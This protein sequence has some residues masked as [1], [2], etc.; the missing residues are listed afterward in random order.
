M[1]SPILDLSLLDGSNGFVIRESASV[2]SAGDINGDGLDD[3]IVGNPFATVDGNS[4]AGES[5]VVFGDAAVG[6]GGV[7]DLTSINGSN[8]FVIS[9]FNA[10]DFLGASV[11]GAGDINDDGIDD[12][13]VG[14][15]GVDPNGN[16]FAGA[17][18]VVFG[19]ASVGAGGAVDLATLNGSNGFA[20]NGIDAGDA[21]GISVSSAG[22]INNDGVDDLIIGALNAQVNGNN[23]VGE[24]YVVFGGAGVG[25]SGSLNPADLDGTNGFIINGVN[26]GERSGYSVSNA[27]DLNGDG[28][29]DLTIGGSNFFGIRAAQGYVVFGDAGVGAGGTVDLAT[30]NGSNG[31]VVN[32]YSGEYSNGSISGAGDINGDG[33]NDLVVGAD[34]SGDGYVVFGSTEIGS[35][36]V[37]PDRSTL[38]GS[39]G[40]VIN[41][42]GAD[43]GLVDPATGAGDIN[44]DGFDD[45][46]FERYVIF[47]GA[48]VGSGGVLNLAFTNGSN[49]FAISGIA[50]YDRSSFFLSEAGD[51]NGD[52]LDDFLIGVPF[53]YD[54]S[55]GDFLSITYAVFG[56]PA[57]TPISIVGTGRSETLNG[58]SQTE[59]LVGLG[60]ND[61]LN[62]N[63]GN[64]AFYGGAGRDTINGSS[65]NDGLDGGEGNDTLNGN[66]G[67]DTFFGGAGN[68]TINARTGNNLVFAGDDR[69]RI[70]TGTGNDIIFGDNP[71]SSFGDDDVINDRGGD[72]FVRSGG[73]DDRVNTGTGNDSVEGDNGNDTLIDRGGTNTLNGGDGDD[74]IQTGAGD[75]LIDGGS[76]SDTIRLNGGKDEVRLEMGLGF[77]TIQ[78]FELGSTQFRVFEKTGLSFA[79]ARGGANVFQDGDQIAFVQGVRASTLSNNVDSVFISFF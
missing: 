44:G 28:I 42:L 48:D 13:I 23:S 18:Y 25:G 46:L 37:L 62:G 60:G 17:S 66:G 57:S 65:G 79:D 63:G 73:G 43:G 71:F 51:I 52:G 40:F 11:S 50:P 8:G 22:D 67:N 54:S 72:N 34:Y 64:D 9:G 56:A 61:T 70:N 38:N 1:P 2:N 77:D 6:T 58:T 5:Y 26:P 45:I 3:F 7:F 20:V 29:D 53:F 36:G 68:D 12:L 21:S 35:G 47:G 76:G 16:D 30:L 55:N 15:T 27:G 33:I 24:S 49:G 14:A 39:N 4:N 69:D 74:I 32:G 41:S 10:Y 19:G 59:T 78:G 31:F 75:D